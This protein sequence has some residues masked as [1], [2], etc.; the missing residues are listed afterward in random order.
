MGRSEEEVIRYWKEVGIWYL[1]DKEVLDCASR[2]VDEHA[3]TCRTVESRVHWGQVGERLR[4]LAEE[5]P[6]VLR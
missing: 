1:T 5:H 2:L 3:R 4:Q 6:P